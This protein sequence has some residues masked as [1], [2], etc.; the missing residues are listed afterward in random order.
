M[1][2][3]NQ[4]CIIKKELHELINEARIIKNIYQVT[5]IESQVLKKNSKVSRYELHEL[6]NES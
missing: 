5:R 2:P 4:S 6:I 1:V 3:K